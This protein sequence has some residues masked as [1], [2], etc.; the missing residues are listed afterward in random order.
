MSML[1]LTI[2]CLIY[3][4]FLNSLN[5]VELN[6][7][8]ERLVGQGVIE[9][10]EGVS[11]LLLNK[12]LDYSSKPE[13]LEFIYKVAQKHSL[14]SEKLKN[15]F[16]E[17]EFQT[18]A[19]ELNT[20]VKQEGD[21]NE[22]RALIIQGADGASDY[23]KIRK[24]RISKYL[25]KEGAEVYE[26]NK[27]L[28]DKISSEY[29]VS[30]E[31]LVATIGIETIYGIYTGKFPI[32]DVLT[33]LAFYPHRRAKLFKSELESLILM[34]EKDHINIKEI[35]G[36]YA[37]AFGLCQ[38]LPSSFRKYA[39]DYDEDGVKDLFASYSDVF[40][41]IANYYRGYE[42]K[43]NGAVGIW[44]TY[45]EKE[46]DKEKVSSFLGRLINPTISSSE[47]F[48]AGIE[49]EGF[50]DSSERLYSLR[51]FKFGKK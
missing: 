32:F 35:K 9:R 1:K 8:G 2:K 24:K 21:S 28:L 13:V 30:S 5:A 16:K 18:K 37:G 12:V 4:S 6:R 49:A 10:G 34:Q 42:W 29:G 38:F 39:V 22:V 23:K 11:K 41:S 14:D 7:V 19:L 40:A 44:G 47:L 25:I 26:N 20:G 36:S 50:I 15:M 27:E 3:L 45:D 17:I 43:P 46:I 48:E 33:T 51:E 31:I